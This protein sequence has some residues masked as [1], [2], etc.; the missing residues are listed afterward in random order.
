MTSPSA[1]ISTPYPDGVQR[2]H[3]GHPSVRSARARE[4]LLVGIGM[5]APLI[6]ALAISVEL[7]RPSA[8]SLLAVVALLL[9]AA[10]VLALML[11]TRYTVTLTLLALY[12]GLLDGPVKLQVASHAGS[13]IRD[14][15]IGALALGMLMRLGRGRERVALPPLSGWVLGFVAVV[16]VEALNPATANVLKALGGYRQLLEW[17]PFFFFGYMMMRS[18]QRFRQ[19]FL[20]LGVMA[21]ANGVVGVYQSRL[22][23]QQLASWG[24]GYSSIAEGGTHLSAR[25][26]KVEGVAHVRPPALGSDAG[27]GGGIGTLAL[28]GLLALLAVGQRR[29]R[30]PVL[31]CCFGALLGI[32]SAASRTSIVVGVLMLVAFAGLSV[33]AGLRIS[34]LL[35]GLVGV[36]VVVCA[37][38]Y[39]LI[40]LDGSGVFKRQETLTTTQRAE[41]TGAS[42]KTESLARI[43][44][45]L[46]HDPLGLGLG[47]AG[48]ASGF[49]GAQHLEVE[50][51][52]AASGS[53]YSL[54]VREVGLPGLALWVGLSLSTIVL[55][56]RR[57]RRIRDDELRTYLVA[58]LAGFIALTIEGLTS[59]TLSVTVGAWLWFVPGVV[60]YWFAGPGRAAMSRG[61][62]GALTS[63]S[64]GALTPSPLG[65][66]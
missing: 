27:F 36:A 13:A 50:G 14:I 62:A 4:R 28:P 59:P 51:E 12:L 37:A 41:E 47:T 38:G 7:P 42:A 48:A 35:V 17:V 11:S 43:P 34:R 61:P 46:I 54:L 60:A 32:A 26:Y 65:A 44:T 6:V 22:S 21:L 25:T 19:L 45:D 20:L 30:W 66:L 1:P 29:R 53:A 57:L 58:L 33:L 49:G 55:A 24:P 31:L 52:K 18:K 3:W 64:V 9:G 10:C 16:L 39:A 56:A 40:S 23:P 8:G 63:S 2:A 5:L 15:L